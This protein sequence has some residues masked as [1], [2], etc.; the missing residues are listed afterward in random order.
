MAEAILQSRRSHRKIANS[1]KPKT[2]D[3]YALFPS[4]GTQRAIETWEKMAQFAIAVQPTFGFSE[5]EASYAK[6]VTILA[7]FQDIPMEVQERLEDSGC[8]VSRIDIQSDEKLI[9]A[10]TE[11]SARKQTAGGNHE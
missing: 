11:F 1:G 4:S 3:H 7:G 10:I 6:K 2:I 5:A 8:V 9:D